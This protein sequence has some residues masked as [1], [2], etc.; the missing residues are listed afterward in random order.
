MNTERKRCMSAL[1]AIIAL[2]SAALIAGDGRFS[3]NFKEGYYRIVCA[4]KGNAHL[5]S[6]ILGALA[7]GFVGLMSLTLLLI[8]LFPFLDSDLY[9][10]IANSVVSATLFL[11][12]GAAICWLKNFLLAQPK[13][14]K[15][16]NWL[17]D[18]VTWRE[19]L[20]AVVLSLV[21]NFLITW[22]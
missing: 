19:D 3:R 22:F 11:A 10:A 7:V 18:R 1:G 12:A 14:R 20:L 16:T 2:S 5:G 4:G 9:W 15:A 21:L 8:S 17:V 13:D 6:V